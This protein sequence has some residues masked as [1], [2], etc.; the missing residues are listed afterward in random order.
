MH[1]VHAHTGPSVQHLYSGVCVCVCVCVCV[2]GESVLPHDLQCTV[3]EDNTGFRQEMAEYDARKERDRL[4]EVYRW[5]KR[6][7][8]GR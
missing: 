3:D 4:R 1:T 7:K 2:D 6:V 8:W 5:G